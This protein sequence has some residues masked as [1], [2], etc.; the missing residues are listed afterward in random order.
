ML[1]LLLQVFGGGKIRV[2]FE[3]Y[4]NGGSKKSNGDCC[5]FFCYTCDNLFTL[6]YCDTRKSPHNCSSP[7]KAAPTGLT[8][9]DNNASLSQ[10]DEF[11]IAFWQWTV[12]KLLD[13]S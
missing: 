2:Q 10:L 7:A 13:S 12:S 1:L 6:T 9:D 3:R 8:F 4:N 5:D 11:E